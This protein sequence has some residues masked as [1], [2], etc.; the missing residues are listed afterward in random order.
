MN[1]IN[2]NEY[3][4]VKNFIKHV[5]END[6][7]DLLSTTYDYTHLDRVLEIVLIESRNIAAK[8]FNK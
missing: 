3:E 4:F 1:H 7:Y 6:L 2:N 5:E 8:I